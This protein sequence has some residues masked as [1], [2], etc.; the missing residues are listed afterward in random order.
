MGCPRQDTTLPSIHSLA[1]YVP[2]TLSVGLLPHTGQS[3]IHWAPKGKTMLLIHNVTAVTVDSLRRI[4][5]EA[6]I[7][8]EDD[9]IL[10]LGKA[11]DLVPRHPDAEP[12]DGRGMLALPGLIDAH[13]HTDQTLLR[14]A[15][16]DLP[17]RPYLKNVIWPLLGQRTSEEVLIGLKLCMLEMIKSGTTCFVDSIVPSHY[18]FDMLAQAVV[19][20]GMRGVLAKYVL[21]GTLFERDTR[22]VDAGSFGTEEESLAD[23]ERGIRA[24]HGAA[25]GRLQVWFGPLVPR[26][27]PAATAS[28]DF[29]RRVSQLAA[30]HGSG[31]TIHLAGSEEDPAFFH[32]EFGMLPAEFALSCGLVGPNVL[33][34]NGTWL[35]EDEIS[36]LA[37]THT[38]LVHSPSA[39]MKMGEG[40][41][42]IPQMR[43][44]GVTVALGCDAGANNNCMDMIR[45]MKA[46]SLLHNV[47]HMDPTTLTAEDA[48][49][50]AT[51]EGARAIGRADELGSLEVGKQADLILVDLK[52]PHTM[53][54][55]DPIANLVY[56]AHGGNVDTVIVAGKVLMQ[57]RKVLV[58][59]E[60]AILGEAQERGQALL[61][62]GGIQVAPEWPI[63]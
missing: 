54:I 29:Y 16:D 61:E 44:A 38:N 13:A 42:K 55:Y 58:A 11:A 30:E 60:E 59:D 26:E 18:D 23:A 2:Y 62:R 6:A 47:T 25:S 24:W 43:A 12:L 50:M 63:E 7:V 37:E 56:A 49:E 36:I 20:M 40:F 53:P 31:I 9:R 1:P 28:P 45:E 32:R 52:Q 4:V 41:A 8:V 35:S 5:T 27:E 46:A 14:S 39:N 34:I 17:W 33:L 57:G 48:L 51:I 3:H 22:L 15:A 19:D 10:E 21:P